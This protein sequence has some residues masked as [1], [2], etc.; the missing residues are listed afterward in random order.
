MSSESIK[1]IWESRNCIKNCLLFTY[2]KFNLI[3]HE[4]F[5]FIAVIAV[6]LATPLPESEAKADPQVILTSSPIVHPHAVQLVPGHS[7]LPLIAYPHHLTHPFIY[8]GI[9][10]D[11]VV[12]SPPEVL[13][14][15]L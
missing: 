3:F 13:Q 2:T 4:I 1:R 7:S 8:H 6:A 12:Q 14:A 15:N 9:P 5:V 11:V 10:T